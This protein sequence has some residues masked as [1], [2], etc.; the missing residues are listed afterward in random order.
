[1][2]SVRIIAY[3]DKTVVK[4]VGFKIDRI[5]LMEIEKKL[6]EILKRPVR[7]IGVS[8]ESLEFDV[9]ELPPEQVYRNERNIIEAIANEGIEG[10]EVAKIV[11]AEQVPEVNLDDLILKPDEE[12]NCPAE[13]WLRW[14]KLE[15]EK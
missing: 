8:G 11:K 14:K 4:I 6:I 15:E 10:V 9:Y 2:G 12:Y 13:R 1:M 5:N 7:V 3:I